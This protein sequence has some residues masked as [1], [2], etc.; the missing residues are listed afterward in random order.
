MPAM[1]TSA[2]LKIPQEV[3][4]QL[5]IY[6][7][8]YI[9]PR[10]NGVFYVGKGQAGRALSHLNAD[11]ES[12]KLA[13]IAEIQAAGQ[14][15]Q[16]DIVQHGIPD[17]DTALRIEAALIDMLGLE[18]LTNEVHGWRYKFLGRSSLSDLVGRYS[19]P[20]KISDPCILIRINKLYRPGMSERELYDATRGIW[21]VGARRS[22]AKFALAVFR[23]VVREVYKIESWHPAGTTAYHSRS[24]IPQQCIGRSEFVGSVAPEPI[25]EEFILGNVSELLSDGSQNPI[26]YVGC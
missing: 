21:K 16:L 22:K 10:T 2:M 26:T 14:E 15:P 19:R 8:A 25:R 9:D 11:G 3:E 23:G 7:Y 12:R 6:V 18:V 13:L 5:G 20:L 17:E 1:Y 24:F 4:E